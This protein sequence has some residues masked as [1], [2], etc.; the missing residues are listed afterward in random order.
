M[1]YF[2]QVLRPSWLSDWNEGYAVFE[3]T[4]ALFNRYGNVGKTYDAWQL[5]HVMMK[6]LNFDTGMTW[7]AN[8]LRKNVRSLMTNLSFD[9]LF[10]FTRTSYSIRGE[11]AH[12]HSFRSR[13]AANT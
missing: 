5:A 8:D 1:L 7:M 13:S 2:Y 10:L 4:E 9:I 3:Q 12:F 6:Y 11:K